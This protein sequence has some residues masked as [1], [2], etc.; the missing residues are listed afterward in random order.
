MLTATHTL[1]STLRAGGAAAP[2]AHAAAVVGRDAEADM[3]A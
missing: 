3:A 1:S 2:A